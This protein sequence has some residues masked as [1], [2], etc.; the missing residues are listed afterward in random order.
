M[1]ACPEAL[2]NQKRKLVKLLPKIRSYPI[3]AGP[4]TPPARW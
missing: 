2:M 1:M 4:S 3:D